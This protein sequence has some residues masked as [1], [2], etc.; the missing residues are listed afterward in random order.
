MWSTAAVDAKKCFN[1]MCTLEILLESSFWPVPYIQYICHEWGWNCETLNSSLDCEWKEAPQYPF[2]CLL[3]MVVH[4]T[5]TMVICH[6]FLFLHH[7]SYSVCP[8]ELPSDTTVPVA[9]ISSWLWRGWSKMVK[10][11]ESE[12]QGMLTCR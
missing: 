11:K 8:C 3:Q 2:I 4:V 12:G 7:F 6:L 1:M 9:W 10:K 5:A